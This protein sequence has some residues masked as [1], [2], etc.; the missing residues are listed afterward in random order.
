MSLPFYDPRFQIT[1]RRLYKYV[2]R[3]DFFRDVCSLRIPDISQRFLSCCHKRRFLRVSP[4]LF[5]SKHSSPCSVQRAIDKIKFPLEH[6]P[7]ENANL[8]FVYPR[9]SPLPVIYNTNKRKN[10]R[11][12]CAI[13]GNK[14]IYI[15][16]TAGH[17]IRPP[18]C[19]AGGA[20]S[21]TKCLNEL[22]KHQIRLACP[23]SE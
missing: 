19:C 3:R 13:R 18:P 4:R 21:M 14:E 16:A 7:P 9:K 15:P 6:Q 5:F 2:F 22:T 10:I 1:S 23:P 8:H 17:L 20:S 12:L 11:K